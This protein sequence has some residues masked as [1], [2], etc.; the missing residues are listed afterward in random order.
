MFQA[1][2]HVVPLYLQQTSKAVAKTFIW[3]ILQ[4]QCRPLFRNTQTGQDHPMFRAITLM[5]WK[6]LFAEEN[7]S[8]SGQR[9]AVIGAHDIEDE[10]VLK[11]PVIG[12]C[13]DFSTEK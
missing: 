5:V 12:R 3:Y 7:F 10:S 8:D 6:T 1:H 2:T 11:I 4:T 9:L 13:C